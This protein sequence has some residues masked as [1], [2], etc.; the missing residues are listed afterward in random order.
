MVKGL[1]SRR[2]S[3]R[4]PFQAEITIQFHMDGNESV[5][6]QATN[7]SIEGVRFFLPKGKIKLAPDDLIDLVFNLQPRGYLEV[8]GEICYFSNAFDSEQNPVVYY[9]VRFLDLSEETQNFISNYCNE[10]TEDPT[11][12]IESPSDS[13]PLTS[14]QVLTDDRATKVEIDTLKSPESNLISSAEIHA[15]ASSLGLTPIEDVPSNVDDHISSSSEDGADDEVNPYRSLSQDL[16]DHLIS[17]INIKSPNMAVLQKESTG[18]PINSVIDVNS[19]IQQSVHIETAQNSSGLTQDTEISVGEPEFQR[20]AID[21]T[22]AGNLEKVNPE[23]IIESPA[24]VTE[25]IVSTQNKP[26]ESEIDIA[27]S[28]FAGFLAQTQNKEGSIFDSSPKIPSFSFD[29]SETATETQSNNLTNTANPNLIDMVFGPLKSNQESPV[30]SATP[31]EEPKV[32]LNAE[33]FEAS[34]PTGET[35]NSKNSVN[36]VM[37]DPNINLFSKAAAPVMEKVIEPHKAEEP[38]EKKWEQPVS[39]I[40]QPIQQPVI[41]PNI[42]NQSAVGNNQPMINSI[43]KNSSSACMDQRMID[44]I[45]QSLIGNSPKPGPNPAP[46]PAPSTQALLNEEISPESLKVI[47]QFDGGK[48]LQSSLERLY[49]GGIIVRIKQEILKNSSVSISIQNKE[50]P[51]VELIGVCANCEFTPQNAEFQAEFFF[52]GLNSMHMETLKTLIVKLQGFRSN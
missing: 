31:V 32:S 10:Q 42:P 27:Q 36:P 38:I 45:I 47:L 25:N 21:S 14:H 46:A 1:I 8:K 48:K 24:P 37:S 13:A 34:E 44:Q 33:K 39:K 7:L 4:I 28:L 11:E 52:K 2:A 15:A 26:G 29:I 51:I 50:V 6:A 41:P 16:I 20:P 43:N 35:G 23:V 17:S 22:I 9:G 49:F 12:K 19:F 3:N 18:N 40:S 30:P 5:I